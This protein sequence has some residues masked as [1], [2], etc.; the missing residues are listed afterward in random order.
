[1]RKILVDGKEIITNFDEKGMDTL[2]TGNNLPNYDLYCRESKENNEEFLK[3]LVSYGYTRIRF[4]EVTT[5]IR[6]FHDVV[7]YC[8]KNEKE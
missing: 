5:R 6:G 2:V 1:M 4:A 8:R 3:R 7:A